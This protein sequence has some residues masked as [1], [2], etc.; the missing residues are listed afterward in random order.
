MRKVIGMTFIFYT[1][2]NQDPIIQN[3]AALHHN[4][5]EGLYNETLA[6]L[7]QMSYQRDLGDNLFKMYLCSQLALDENPFSLMAEKEDGKLDPVLEEL[8][9]RDLEEI[10]E[11]AKEDP[12]EMTIGSKKCSPFLIKIYETLV[13]DPTP[14]S[15]LNS[16]YE[17]YHTY[18]AGMMNAYKAFKWQGGKGLVGIENCDTIQLKDLLN[19]EYQKKA[20][21]KNTESFL[22]GN[23][24]NNALL[25]GDAG[26]GKSSSVKAILNAYA[27]HGLRMIEVSK[28]DFIYFNE[29]VAYLK[30]RGLK[31]IIFLDDLSFEEFETEYKAM[32]AMIEGGI[33]PKPDNVLLY[34]TSNR[35]HLIRETWNERQGEDVH[36]QDTRQEKLSLSDRFGLTL[37]F[38]SPNQ[39]AYLEMVYYLAKK[40]HVALDENTLREKALQWG[41]L[42]GGRSGRIAKQFIQSII[43]EL[44]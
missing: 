6:K 4:Y 20:L 8:V 38:T 15:L 39:N 16:L 1:R 27:D 42:H 2:L 7:V 9:L 28:S 13:D 36:I 19:C 23:L 24:A 32:K 44:Q 29:M 5:N 35:R 30:K 18:G 34:A 14:E 40:H 37:T 21:I 31:F 25:F 12:F 3:V 43:S 10:V 11:L 41:L 26:T 33:E 17:G 22:K